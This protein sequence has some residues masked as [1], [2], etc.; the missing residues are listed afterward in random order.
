MNYAGTRLMPAALALSLACKGPP[1]TAATT[2]SVKISPPVSLPPSAPEPSSAHT[3]TAPSI[4]TGRAL[5]WY[6]LEI[7]ATWV[8]SA[9]TQSVERIGN[10]ERFTSRP[11]S[12]TERCIESSPAEPGIVL[13]ERRLEERVDDVRPPS[14]VTTVQRLSVRDDSIV[15]L[16]IQNDGLMPVPYER[17][18]TLF[19]FAPDAPPG[20]ETVQ[21]SL[22]L[23]LAPASLSSEVVQVPAG[24]FPDALKR[25]VRGTVRGRWRMKPV[26]GGTVVETAWFVRGIGPVKVERTLSMEVGTGSPTIPVTEDSAR[27]LISYSKLAEER[28]RMEKTGK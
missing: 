5:D 2:P 3:S 24:E 15:A 20:T 7:G 26:K 25:V 16:S 8:Y 9:T 22:H 27:T 28:I 11:G 10:K 6:P 18:Y 17:P 19:S 21:Y 13:L 1:N 4:A 14:V 23:D 12:I